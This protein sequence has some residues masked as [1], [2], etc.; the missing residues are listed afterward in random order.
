MATN[1]FSENTREL[2]TWDRQRCYMCGMNH[3]DCL[4]HIKGRGYKNDK[5]ESSPLNAAPVSN[6]QC[7]LGKNMHTE[8]IER[9]LLNKTFDYLLSVGYSLTENDKEFIGK[10]KKYY[11]KNGE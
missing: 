11:A 1:N 2:F 7:H 10:Y 3:A 8:E 9:K 5:A 6:T 4:H